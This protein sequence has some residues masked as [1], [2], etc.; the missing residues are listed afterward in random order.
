M[1]VALTA[2][3]AAVPVVEAVAVA[4]AAAT[5][6]AAKVAAQRVAIDEQVQCVFVQWQVVNDTG[7]KWPGKLR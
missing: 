7:L 4:V 1:V 5:P 2:N 3:A 6:T